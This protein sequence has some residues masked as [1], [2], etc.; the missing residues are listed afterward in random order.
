MRR[1]R[2]GRLLSTLAVALG[3]VALGT[4]A[5]L[6]IAKRQATGKWTFPTGDDVVRIGRRVSSQTEPPPPPPPPRIIYLHSGPIRLVGGLDDAA[7]RRSSVVASAGAPT[8]GH[9]HGAAGGGAATGGATAAPAA[10]TAP[11]EVSLRGFRG[12]KKSWRQIVTCVEKLF[13]PF[14]VVVTETEPPPGTRYVMAVVGGRPRDLGHKGRVAG[15]APFSGGVV[16]NAVVFAFSDELGNRVRATCEV[17]GM[18]V[19]H[20]FGLDH[21]H[22]CKD[23]M[24]Y[25][26]GCGAKAFRDVDARCGESKPRDCHGGAA[27]QNSY[28][29]LLSVLGPAGGPAAEPGDAR[30]TTVSAPAPPSGPR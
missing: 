6:V 9:T 2:S 20:A 1:G 18:E 5:G 27:T 8:G 21:A 29:R 26:R 17:I 19:A 13:A 12:S 28:R 3:V 14:D 30:A 15:L 22:H 7:G 4:V 11:R 10:A 23:V 25:L 24:T 16:Q